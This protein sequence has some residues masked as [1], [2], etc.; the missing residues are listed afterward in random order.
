VLSS[1]PDTSPKSVLRDDRYPA[2]V[3]IERVRSGE[4]RRVTEFETPPGPSPSVVPGRRQRLRSPSE[5]PAATPCAVHGV[6]YARE[7]CPQLLVQTF[8]RCVTIRA[9]KSR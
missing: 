8:P 9:E 1:T 4:L 5:R 6:A 2:I 3:L 7:D